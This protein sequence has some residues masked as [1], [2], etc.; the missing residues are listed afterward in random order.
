MTTVERGGPGSAGPAGIA[1]RIRAAAARRPPVSAEVG[2]LWPAS[3]RRNRERG[4]LYS[5]F[6]LFFFSFFLSAFLS[7]TSSAWA[8]IFSI[9]RPA[10]SGVR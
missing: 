9:L 4:V 5:V 3:S 8:S 10:D 2:E 6:L 1:R 7:A